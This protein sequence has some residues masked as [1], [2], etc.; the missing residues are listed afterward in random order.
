MLAERKGTDELYAIKILKKDIIIQVAFYLLE[1]SLQKMHLNKKDKFNFA[2]HKMWAI[3]NNVWEMLNIQGKYNFMWKIIPSQR[4]LQWLWLRIFN[5][6]FFC[7]SKLKCHLPP[8]FYLLQNCSALF[9]KLYVKLVIHC[10]F[11]IN[12]N[13]NSKYSTYCLYSVHNIINCPNVHVFRMTMLIVQ[14]WRSACL[15]WRLNR[16]F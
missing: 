3:F 4:C 15:Q 5:K 10:L 1:H 16:H 14:W 9:K 2:F 13:K 12:M 7:S 6:F 8:F 11:R